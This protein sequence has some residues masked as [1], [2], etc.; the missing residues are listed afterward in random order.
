MYM[1]LVTLYCPKCGHW[2]IG[3]HIHDGVVKYVCC[4]CDLIFEKKECN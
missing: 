4:N 2:C 3:L 1:N